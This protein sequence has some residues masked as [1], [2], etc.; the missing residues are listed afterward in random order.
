MRTNITFTGVTYLQVT[1]D[2]GEVIYAPG[3]YN[4][5]K[6]ASYSM[7]AISGNKLALK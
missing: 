1:G 3:F 4:L 6:Y 5:F 7:N 2:A